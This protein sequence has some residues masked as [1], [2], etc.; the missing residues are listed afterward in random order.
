M[1]IRVAAWLVKFL[2][3]VLVSTFLSLSALAEDKSELEALELRVAELVKAERLAEALPA[4]EKAVALAERLHGVQAAEVAGALLRLGE[5]LSGLNR[6]ADAE[7]HERRALAIRE[8]TLGP[9]HQDIAEAMIAAAGSLQELKR[10]D[11]AAVLYRRALAIFETSLGAGHIKVADAVS[12]LA[13]IAI[14]QG[15]IEEAEALYQ[16]TLALREK[17]FGP[18]HEDLLPPILGLVDIA[19][20]IKD[21]AKAEGLVARAVAIREKAH[22]PDDEVTVALFGALGKLFWSLDRFAEAEPLARRVLAFREKASGP[23]HISVT[24]ALVDLADVHKG[25][26]RY[27]EA[28]PLYRRALAMQEKLLGPDHL[29]VARTLKK[30]AQAYSDQ[31][32]FDLMEPL[33]VRTLSI[34]EQ[35]LEPDHLDVLSALD[36]LASLYHIQGRYPDSGPL[37][38][39][40][41]A[42]TEKVR[43]KDHPA[44]AE[45]LGKLAGQLVALGRFTEAEPLMKRNL[46]I[47]ENAF[48]PA[49]SAVA[50]ALM[51]QSYL[52]QSWNRP[53]DAEPLLKRALSIKE[54]LDGRESLAV[55]VVLNNL[56][57][58]YSDEDRN[59]EAEP[60]ARRA[61]TIFENE[62]GVDH[63]VTG[64]AIN[65]LAS[66][67]SSLNRE[68][69]TELLYH[70]SIGILENAMGPEHPF[71]AKSLHNLGHLYRTQKR[72]G[73]A[74]PVI[75]RAISMSEK[76][77][78]PA[79]PDFANA[80]RGL[81][82][83]YADQGRTADAIPLHRRS[84]DILTVALGPDDTGVSNSL[85]SLAEL[86]FAEGD[87]AEAA[88]SWR[89][90]TGII[91]RRAR[92]GIGSAGAP[93]ERRSI[94]TTRWSSQFRGF[95]KAGYRLATMP[96]GSF[97]GEIFEIAQWGLYSEAA[98][99]L[100]QMAA[101]GAKGDG[102]LARLARERQDLVADWRRRDAQ[103]LEAVAT[104]KDKRDTAAEA[105]NVARL[106][107]I[108]KRLADI[109][110]RLATAFPDFAALSRPE[111]LTVAEIQGLLRPD[112]ALV[113][114]F[115]TGELKPAPEETFV[116]VVTKS[117]MRWLRA[118]LGT[119]ALASEVAVLRCGL[120]AATWDS[121]A[122]RPGDS[123]AQLVESRAK[124]DRA[125]ACVDALG[126]RPIDSS[127]TSILPFD[128][129]RAHRLY[130]SLLGEARDMI[131]GKHLLIVPSGPLTQLP[132]QV[133]AT[134]PPPKNGDHKKVA[135][136][137]RDHAITVLPSVSSLK[138]L[139][140][141]A[142]PSTASR[143][144]IGFGNPLLDGGPNHV[145]LAALAGD[146]QRCRPVSRER[147]VAV[148]SAPIG[149]KPVV[150]RGGLANAAHLK[151]Q[152]PLPETADELCAV[153]RDLNADPDDVHLGAR[154]TEAEIKALSASGR[155][156]Q[157]RIVHFATHG[158]LAG[159]ISGA[160]EPGLILTPPDVPSETDDGY[161]SGSE[162]AALKLD[163]D[164]V[165]LSA[166]NT[167]GPAGSEKDLGA[168]R[169][170]EALSG[171]ARVFFY[172]GAR[173]LLVSHWAVESAAA[174]KLITH[175]AGSIARD[176]IVGR[177]EALRRSMLAMIDRG[178]PHEAH[179]ATWAP[180]V[181]V[182]EGGARKMV[183]GAG[184][185]K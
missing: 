133:L 185:K 7:L 64:M 15:R 45:I 144:M 70:R 97:G 27:G 20:K 140:R 49:H 159:E 26:K 174:V 50:D 178:R 131:K 13:Q 141:V 53:Q 39:R 107:E 123:D 151:V 36:D 76:A 71:V 5:V 146:Y 66:V 44:V 57:V 65:N 1:C 118:D 91:V 127:G 158:T 43:G 32:R 122:D 17:A 114:F 54:K 136:L 126:E 28:E 18:E 148:A 153:A 179:P 22:G 103:R 73:E 63:A 184:R 145:R 92:R 155:L 125:N 89:R 12:P 135:W 96:G 154:A 6:Y 147:M 138:A 149:L 85:D 111:P 112:E 101:R 172:A 142:R 166:C 88:D 52:Y 175:A 139:R 59:Q 10:L 77:F 80:L 120:D 173:A 35:T 93:I 48:G 176:P 55:A 102:E 98:A 150:I 119:Q 42:M 72:F 180:F 90:S 30:L 87:W 62:K 29:D 40:V 78:G 46:T 95:A 117:N 100:A 23:E 9:D 99:S 183:G 19:I 164:W 181:V 157:Y 170:G 31:G 34:R 16:R 130:T 82:W 38:E 124:R 163:A 21:L 51:F 67:L 168:D 83:L 109:D 108:D 137:A 25:L 86:A 94:E 14:S 169:S 81:A 4:A 132:F 74:E 110:A 61:L 116:W 37:Y 104:E 41:L 171:L 58:L 69:E 60:L 68:G 162:I 24:T 105:A 115:D 152:T 79:H 33:Y 165:I 160:R 161:L 182:G 167:A 106:G 75:K 129:V 84:I 3:T 177:A 143:P 2:T 8:K 47:Q 128:H 56:T 11:E 113:A 134:R 121:P 156:A